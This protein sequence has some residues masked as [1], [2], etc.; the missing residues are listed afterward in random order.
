MIL[1]FVLISVITIQLNSVPHF[2]VLFQQH[3][4]NHKT[5]KKYAKLA[6]TNTKIM[7]VKFATGFDA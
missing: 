7:Q 4:S 5:S 6:E 3:R 2:N 1:F